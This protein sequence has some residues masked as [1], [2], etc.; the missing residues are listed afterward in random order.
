MIILRH[1]MKSLQPFRGGE[2][3]DTFE[4]YSGDLFA[5]DANML[6]SY[7]YYTPMSGNIGI[8]AHLGR[9]DWSGY[10]GYTNLQGSEV[11]TLVSVRLLEG[12]NYNDSIVTYVIYSGSIIKQ[13]ADNYLYGLGGHDWIEAGLGKDS[14]EGGLG[15]DTIYGELQDDDGGVFAQGV[16]DILYGNEGMDRLFG[17]WGHDSLYG[18]D[19]NDTLAGGRGNDFLDGGN[20]FDINSFVDYDDGFYFDLSTGSVTGVIDFGNDTL[21]SIEGWQGSEGNDTV[22]GSSGNDW[23]DGAGGVDTLEGGAGADTLNGGAG[24]DWVSYQSSTAAVSVN[25]YTGATSGG[26]AQGDVLTSIS[27]LQ[28]SAYNDTL[29]GDYSNNFLY[30]EA[31]N[32]RLNGL[33]GNDTLHGDEGNDYLY[34]DYDHDVLYGGD[35]TDSLYGAWGNDSL[36]GDAGTDLIRGGDQNDLLSGGDGNDTLTGDLGN[37]TL[38]GGE[39]ADVFEFRFGDN[40]HDVITDFTIGEDQLDLRYLGQTIL[41][42]FQQQLVGSDM[43]ITLGGAQTVTLSGVTQLL[44]ATDVM[45]Y[46]PLFGEHMLTGT[47]MFGHDGGWDT[48]TGTSAN[49][50]L[51]GWSGTDILNG[52]DGDDWIW[53][54]FTNDGVSGGAGN[55]TIW[56]EEGA[57]GIA[58]QEGNDILWGA[59]ERIAF[60]LKRVGVP[61]R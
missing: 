30:G 35:G 52:G 29:T 3:N 50:V 1:S 5:N 8:D 49:D 60:P 55:D 32:D 44:A 27:H 15:N 21:V 11:D 7:R 14:V 25:L 9:K 56:G 39:G 57:D 58:G 2:G 53:G 33:L 38:T 43:V 26:D 18:G 47:V 34:G 17:Q 13:D 28:G 4:S 23:F 6:V 48:L 45:S 54:G 40:G 16:S 22:Y 42:Y 31:G 51:V 24:A 12:S 46:V 20:G 10:W 37:D 36:Y 41:P 59:R 19:D 61:I